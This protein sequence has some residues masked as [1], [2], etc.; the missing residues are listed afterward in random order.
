MPR[1]S[2]ND[3]PGLD[4]IL[5]AQQELEEKIA[6]AQAVPKQLELEIQEREST[7]PAPD[8]LLERERAKRF[9]EQATRGQVRN[10]RRTQGRSLLLLFLLL[11]ATA[12]M[13]SWIVKLAGQ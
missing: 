1:P 7:I 3:D 13:I 11:L 5:R 12:A 4:E 10:E 6:A 2:S 9:E 8:D